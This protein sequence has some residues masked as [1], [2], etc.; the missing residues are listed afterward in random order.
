MHGTLLS[1]ADAPLT[2]PVG[3]AASHRVVSGDCEDRVHRLVV[4]IGRLVAG[5]SGRDSSDD[6]L[7][8]GDALEMI[9]PLVVAG[10]GLVAVG[11]A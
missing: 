1:D 6:R 5:G 3:P 2:A 4:L 8:V 7:P 11:L 10:T 9:C